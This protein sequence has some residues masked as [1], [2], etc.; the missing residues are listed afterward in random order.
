MV[1]TVTLRLVTVVIPDAPEG[2]IGQSVGSVELDACHS[3]LPILD[4]GI[5]IGL[6]WVELPQSRRTEPAWLPR[7]P[8]EPLG[9]LTRG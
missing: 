3:S 5:S 1:A 4:R 9:A 2:C 8:Q 7:R 6:R